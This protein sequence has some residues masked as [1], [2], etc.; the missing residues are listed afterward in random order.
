MAFLDENVTPGGQDFTDGMNIDDSLI[1]C[2]IH[3]DQ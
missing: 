1:N 2:A 3:A